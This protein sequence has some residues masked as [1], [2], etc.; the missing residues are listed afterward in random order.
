VQPE[1]PM[2]QGSSATDLLQGARVLLVEDQAVNRELA[3]AM[4]QRLGCHVEVACDGRAGMTAALEGQHDVVLMDCQMPE[5][6]GFA[7]TEAIRRAETKT[8]AHLPII[9]LTANAITGDRELCKAA[10]M[11]DYMTKPFT[12][13]QL[14]QMLTQWL[15]KSQ[16]N[17]QAPPG[18]AESTALAEPSGDAEST[19]IDTATLDSIRAV[20]GNELLRRMIGLF[21]AETP[22]LLQSIHT[23]V[24]GNNP[25][26]VA[27]AT[28]AL[29]SISQ[30]LGAML[31]AR[32]CKQVE[33]Q[34]RQ[35][36]VP[37]GIAEQLDDALGKTVAA[38]QSILEDPMT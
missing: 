24:T 19:R 27:A 38:L 22:L 30:N 34:A 20:G 15:V 35:G 21:L 10:G 37:Q 25:N 31:L 6:D 33:Q 8:G 32:L 13:A 4:L 5:M 9:A 11:D 23:A 36:A 17:A 16:G 7:A 28:H 2:A 26:G 3:V 14:A 29:K 18:P 1:I 12:R